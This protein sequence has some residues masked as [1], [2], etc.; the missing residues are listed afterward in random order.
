MNGDLQQNG[1]ITSTSLPT[2]KGASQTNQITVT[3]ICGMTAEQDWREVRNSLIRWRGELRC[4]P[5][6]PQVLA[7][8]QF[9]NNH[10][11]LKML[12][13]CSGG[14]E[15][16]NLFWWWP[17]R[18]RE[19]CPTPVSQE[20][21]WLRGQRGAWCATWGRVNWSMLT[22]KQNTPQLS[23]RPVPMVCG[24]YRGSFNQGWSLPPLSV[25]SCF[26]FITFSA[27]PWLLLRTL[28]K[29]KSPY[30][31][32]ILRDIMIHF[33][34]S[35]ALLPFKRLNRLQWPLEGSVFGQRIFIRFWNVNFNK[36]NKM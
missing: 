21:Q 10:R 13:I 1:H 35:L 19:L 18:F 27:G 9:N 15:G 36:S 34:S 17:L 24:N 25:L 14:G 6:G 5:I 22:L 12:D 11:G 16:M 33:A 23:R 2:L 29:K 32:Y 28:L 7:L 4:S 8:W 3:V 26:Q 20:L 31:L 30:H